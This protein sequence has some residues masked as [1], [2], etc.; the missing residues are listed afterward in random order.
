MCRGNLVG[1]ARNDSPSVWTVFLL[2]IAAFG[3]FESINVLFFNAYINCFFNVY[4]CHLQNKFEIFISSRI[5]YF[6]CCN[7]IFS[8]LVLCFR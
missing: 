2:K 5:S 7:M 6:G 3:P 1:A 8:V 4:A